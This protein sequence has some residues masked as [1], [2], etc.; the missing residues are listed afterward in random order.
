VSVTNS[1]TKLMG[2]ESARR[3][4]AAASDE[5]VSKL[6]TA[7]QRARMPARLADFARTRFPL[8][9]VLNIMPLGGVRPAS[10]TV[11]SDSRLRGLSW[12]R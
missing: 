8:E 4:D 9:T 2:S 5:Q 6:I 12:P 7:A 10:V 1:L 3:S 11:H